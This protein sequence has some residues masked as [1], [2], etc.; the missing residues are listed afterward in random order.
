VTEKKFSVRV[1]PHI[2]EKKSVKRVMLEVLICLLPATAAGAYF[3]GLRALYVMAAAVASAVAAE[4]L[5][6]KL[7][8]RKITIHDGSAALTGLLL[9]LILPPSVPLWIPVVGSFFAIAIGKQAYGGLGGNIFNPALIGRV[10]LLAA[11]PALLT[12]WM[13]PLD[14]GSHDLDAET[15]A[16]P[17]G[18]AKLEGV[19]Q[20]VKNLGGRDAAYAKLAFGKVGGC[21]GETSAIALLIGGAALILL[22]NADWRVPVGYL[23]TVG[24]LSIFLGQDPLFHLLAGGLMLG[25]FFMATDP[26]TSPSTKKGRWVFA[27]GCGVITVV[28]RLY[29]GLPEGVSYAILLMNAA[30]PLIDRHILPRRFGT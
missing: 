11:W 17:L 14:T 12:T 18:V 27:V 16:T 13:L 21:V 10:F 8:G 22:G 19:E 23:G 9:A 7:M 25:A 2:F 29:S 24:I 4:A 28:L 3:F 26:V 6:Q 5:C 30:T 15:G 1:S 20:S